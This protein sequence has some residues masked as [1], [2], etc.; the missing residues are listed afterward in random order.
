M[1]PRSRVA[2][3]ATATAAGKRTRVYRYEEGWAISF[4]P[5]SFD[6]WWYVSDTWREAMDLAFQ[7]EAARSTGQWSA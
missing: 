5:D 3:T 7:L 2:L 6:L 4:W 1:T